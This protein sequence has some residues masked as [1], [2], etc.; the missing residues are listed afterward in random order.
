MS[1]D[2][3]G[4]V[5]VNETKSLLLLILLVVLV[6]GGIGLALRLNK[7]PSAPATG[8]PAPR[9]PAAPAAHA[10]PPGSRSANATS[11]SRPRRRTR[12]G[13][14]VVRP[15]DPPGDFLRWPSDKPADAQGVTSLRSG[16]V[17]LN[18]S[19][20]VRNNRRVVEV[21]RSYRLP[22]A[23]PKTWSTAHFV[24]HVLN[25]P[26]L[27]QRYD[28]TAEQLAELKALDLKVPTLTKEQQTTIADLFTAAETARR[29]AAAKPAKPSKPATSSPA[30][31][32]DLKKRAADAEAAL[33]KAAAKLTIP[34]A[35]L[36]EMTED[37][38]DAREILRPD[39][40]DLIDSDF[41][42]TTSGFDRPGYPRR[43][44]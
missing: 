7:T 11:G 41:D 18:I 12:R 25:S 22:E 6:G 1:H 10:P 37:A 15:P 38:A 30:S 24:E 31:Q 29:E 36:D 26:T 4:P 9:K 35:E 21:W 23:K 34:P 16:S 3:T 19:L 17:Y 14:P 39:Q 43:Q 2:T 28:V 13:G 33:M 27:A 44:K 40:L 32:P 42:R 8:Q 5:K 20:I